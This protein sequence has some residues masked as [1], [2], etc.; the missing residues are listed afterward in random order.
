M[1]ILIVT[2]HAMHNPGSVYQAYALQ[3]YLLFQGQ[4]AEI[5]DYRPYYFYSE[6]SLIKYFLKITL[7]GLVY[8]KLSRLY[9]KFIANNLK[10]TSRVT[11]YS[12][13]R[14][15]S[16]NYDLYIV[17][18]DQLWNTDYD[19]GWDPAF[20]LKFIG[21]GVKISYSTSVGKHE[22]DSQN[23]R[24][25]K[26]NLT[27]FNA[28]SVREKSTALQLSQILN[29]KVEW[30]CDPVFLLNKQDYSQFIGNNLEN[31]KYALVYMSPSSNILDS[32]VDYLKKKNLKIILLGGFTK[33]CACDLH[34]KISGPIEFIT[35]I[36]HAEYVISTSFHATAFSLLF[37]K[38]FL[39]LLPPKNGERIISLLKQAGLENRYVSSSSF[40]VNDIES[41]IE[42][43]DV[44]KNLNIYIE[45]SKDYLNNCIKMYNH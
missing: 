23:E 35:F 42:W 31:K 21:N 20:Y 5:L 34:V 4:D 16:Y 27:S 10:L 11:T 45:H 7:C 18:S 8:F 41:G 22:I 1:K 44:D 3:K 43:A 39:T 36:S 38:S 37:H 6:K 40:C 25:L 19:C 32:I 17:G 24:L 13:L 14:K 12:E 15:K 33:R 26:E 30:V 9:N 29:K 28:L 2:L